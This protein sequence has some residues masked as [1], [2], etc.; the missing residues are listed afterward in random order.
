LPILRFF[1]FAQRP[2]ADLLIAGFAALQCGVFDQLALDAAKVGMQPDCRGLGP[3]GQ[4]AWGR[5][6]RER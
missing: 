2:L 3:A 4:V 5:T 1:E 6:Q